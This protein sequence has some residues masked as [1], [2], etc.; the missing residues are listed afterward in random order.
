MPSTDPAPGLR[1]RRRDATRRA[2]EDAA[3]RLFARDGFD[4]TT[5]ETICAAAEVSPRTFF[6]YFATKDEVLNPERRA[7]QARLRDVVAA[8]SLEDPDDPDDLDVALA[9]LAALAADLG[10]DRE[11]LLLQ[12]QAVI[13][14]PAL[15]GRTYDVLQSWQ[16]TLAAALAA[17]RGAPPDDLAA[18]SAAA[19]AIGVWQAVVAR[20]LDDR[21]DPDLGDLLAEAVAGLGRA[22]SRA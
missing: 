4:A 8:A 14:S 3:L 10:T 2:L 17:R 11:R 20:W 18:L 1:E 9:A 6:R 21:A 12:R 16:Q 13:T 22:G 15:R 19:A 7:R 5:V